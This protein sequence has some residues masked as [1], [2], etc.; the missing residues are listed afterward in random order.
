M[1][2]F[3]ILTLVVSSPF[4][5]GQDSFAAA[6]TPCFSFFLVFAFT[7]CSL[8]VKGEGGVIELRSRGVYH[9]GESLA[10]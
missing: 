5:S 6:A 3:A 9:L 10:E 8:V 2:S 1:C 7:P 4:T